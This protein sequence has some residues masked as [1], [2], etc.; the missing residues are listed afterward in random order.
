MG[1]FESSL[2]IE[3]FTVRVDRK[4]ERFEMKE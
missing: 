2:T 3:E 1:G 4:N